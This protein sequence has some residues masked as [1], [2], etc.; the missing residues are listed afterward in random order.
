MY[1][2]KYDLDRVSD[3]VAN[4]L[5]EL[6]T[7]KPP[8]MVGIY[9]RRTDEGID[10][11]SLVPSFKLVIVNSGDMYLSYNGRFAVVLHPQKVQH[12]LLETQ[13]IDPNVKLP[14]D[15][16][17]KVIVK[18]LDGGN[19]FII[20]GFI[21]KSNEKY[22]GVGNVEDELFNTEYDNKTILGWL[23]SDNVVM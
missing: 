8:E 23:P 6:S 17:E 16:Y 21:W 11:L 3:K 13:W 12:L 9:N 1:L 2:K 7:D 18:Y 5:L 14:K 22:F 15:M 4:R 10:I 20:T 19:I